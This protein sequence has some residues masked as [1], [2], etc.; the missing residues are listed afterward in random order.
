MAAARR[1][2]FHTTARLVIAAAAAAASLAA[3]QNEQPAKPAENRPKL[4]LRAR[5]EVSITP[6]RVVFTAELV[7]GA[8][9]FEDY[10]C[11]TV[12]WEWGDDT[13]SEST[14]DCQPYEAG[15]SEIRRRFTVEHTFKRSGIYKVFFRLKRRDKAVATATTN[16][17]VR[18]GARDFGQ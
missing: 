10:Y 14:L 18:P 15:K 9:D 13:R 11:P 12:E 7:G 2:A 16:I 4:T 3:A 5:P 1:G 6:A 8:N 17:T